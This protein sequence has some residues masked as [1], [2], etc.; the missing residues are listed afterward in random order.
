MAGSL[1]TS[2]LGELLEV[3]CPVCDFGFEV[4]MVDAACQIWR[5]CPCCRSRVHFVE[6]G[7]ELHG[8]MAEIDS[9]VR[10][11]EKSLRRMFK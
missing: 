4:Q 6:P 1:S 5:W 3:N 2:L 8:A 7:G 9:A 10:E 11:F